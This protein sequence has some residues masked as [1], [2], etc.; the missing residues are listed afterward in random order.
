MSNIGLKISET[1]KRLFKEGILVA[2]NKGKG[3]IKKKCIICGKEF[4]SKEFTKKKHCSHKCY[5]DNIKAWNK[6]ITH[7]QDSRVYS[8]EKKIETKK[9]IQCKKEFTNHD[10]MTF[11]KNFNK[12]VFCSYACWKNHRIERKKE[13]WKKSHS[14]LIEEEKKRLIKTGMRVISIAKVIPDLIAISGQNIKITAVEVERGTYAINNRLKNKYKDNLDY[15][16]VSW[17][18]CKPKGI[19][20]NNIKEL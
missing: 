13:Y 7:L 9:C 15:D 19:G 1:K 2:W 18:I 8:P 3:D 5:L 17:V 11:G 14:E 12:R 16:D 6:G 20:R 4:I 10:V